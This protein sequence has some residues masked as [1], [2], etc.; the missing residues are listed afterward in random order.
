MVGRGKR[1]RRGTLRG[2]ITA[3]GTLAVAVG[4]LVASSAVAST[5][6]RSLEQTMV[7]SL[8]VRARDVVVSR[9]S[10]DRDLPVA[11]EDEAV[12]QVVS[13]SGVV[14][15]QSGN[16]LSVRPIA[17]LTPAA[18][19][20]LTKRVRGV[21]I[22]DEAKEPFRLVA[23]GAAERGGSYTVLVANNLDQINEAVARVRFV[24]RAGLP[25]LL[26]LVALTIWIV[27]GSA[28]R[29]VAAIRRQVA[30]ISDG[31]LARR[32]FD[33]GTDDE[34]GRL[35]RAMNEMLARLEIAAERQA[36]FVADASHELQSPLAAI[37]ADLEV[38]SAHPGAIPWE[39]AAQGVV[40]DVHRMSE[41]IQ[42]LLFL[43]RSENAG[44][45]S[46][47]SLV[48]V[49]ELVRTEVDRLRTRSS[50]VTITSELEAIEK[51]TQPELLGR[52]VRN[53]I[54][55]AVRHAESEVRVELLREAS[56]IILVVSDD[57]PG[58]PVGQRE[59]IFERF[60]RLDDSRSRQTG[61]TGLGLAITREIVRHL[62]GT[63]AV[64]DSASGA[65]LVV[66]LPVTDS[67]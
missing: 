42:D 18:G 61:G 26:V 34:I 1:A 53:L 19:T 46:T 9:A 27:V 16:L 51:R 22:R 29:P 56:T 49:D 24:L 33:P 35:A 67:R 54:D 20:S 47:A 50:H 4:L 39:E 62:G 30:E 28:L 31:D 59:R 17:G 10:G 32:V 55:N 8:L 60:A 38:A 5:L 21:Q 36:R 63:V 43:A 7:K 45:G 23:L 6:R 66:H 52:V 44:L 2:K 13:A 64:E 58:I 48:D 57:G 25:F 12:V 11:G 14:I 40:A 15:A 41:L 37:L 3:V 65:R